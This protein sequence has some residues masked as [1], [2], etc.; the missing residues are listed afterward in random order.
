M[1]TIQENQA[2]KTSLISQRDERAS[3]SSTGSDT[4]PL[5][6]DCGKEDSSFID[7]E[8]SRNTKSAKE[9]E[10]ET[11]F[12]MA[13]ERY[14]F[15]KHSAYRERTILGVLLTILLISLI[16]LVIY[17]YERMKESN[18]YYD[19]EI[20]YLRNKIESR[21][22]EYAEKNPKLTKPAYTGRERKAG[23][24]FAFDKGYDNFGKVM[25]KVV[26]SGGLDKSQTDTA[27][28]HWQENLRQGNISFY[29]GREVIIK[30]AGYYLIQVRMF[31]K[32]NENY[33]GQH[34][35]Y[36]VVRKGLHKET[37]FISSATRP[38][39]ICGRACSLSISEIVRLDEGDMLSIQT[40]KSGQTFGM[41]KDKA[42]FGVC[43]LN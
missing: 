35:D 34:L 3:T 17:V 37:I 21:D 36:G 5:V 32:G 26:G 42:S 1:D 43:K 40:K 29:Q 25:I 13:F 16:V 6:R 41:Y 27:L 39:D 4:V 24:S 9:M 23:T 28:N 12:S 15:G 14:F 22:L 20:H 38:K 11:H 18:E 31:F 2:I 30:I 10:G 19:R 33:A 7:V 8:N